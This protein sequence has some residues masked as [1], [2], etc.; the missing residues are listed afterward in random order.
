MNEALLQSVVDELS[1]VLRGR[2]F[3][4][5]FQLSKQSL[6]IDFRSGDGR[7]LY[8]NLDSSDPRIFLISRKLKEIEKQSIHLSPF[9]LS[10]RKQLSGAVLTEVVR[11]ADDRIVRFLFES[12]DVAGNDLRRSMVVQLTGRSANLLVLDEN[13]FIID[14]F[15]QTRGEGQQVGEKYLAPMSHE[16]T[17]RPSLPQNDEMMRA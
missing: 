8:I 6:A 12:E 14:A 5:I 17:R 1:A 3:G 2:I 9:S 15:R 13:G 10:L 11:D 16:G 7:Y 4:K